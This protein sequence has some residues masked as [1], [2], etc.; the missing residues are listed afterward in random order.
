M[1][2]FCLWNALSGGER[3]T[4][5]E[6][7]K[8]IHTLYSFTT[9]QSHPHGCRDRRLR[10]REGQR[11]LG[12]TQ[13]VSKG[14]VLGPRLNFLNSDLPD[15]CPSPALA[16]PQINKVHKPTEAWPLST[17]HVICQGRV[18]SLPAGKD[19]PNWPWPLSPLSFCS[20]TWASA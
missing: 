5:K 13:Q 10:P 9:D 2:K 16:C 17:F 6:T 15:Y 19:F 11:Q 3:V 1:A 4:K 8:G 12:A 7:H 18:M 20:T 14:S